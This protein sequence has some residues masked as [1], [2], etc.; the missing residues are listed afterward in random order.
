MDDTSEKVFH[1]NLSSKKSI[2]DENIDDP[3]S[4]ENSV[5]EEF[6]RVTN[7]VFLDSSVEED[8]SDEGSETMTK[9]P[10]DS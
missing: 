7:N 2:N 8:L 4:F 5:T 9:Q 6:F 10:R 3:K 1:F